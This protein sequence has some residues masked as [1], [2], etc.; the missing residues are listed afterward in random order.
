[1]TGLYRSMPETFA[2]DL[3]MTK[4]AYLRA[5]AVLIKAGLLELAPKER[6]LWVKPMMRYQGT[7]S[8][9]VLKYVRS[10]LDSLPPNPLVE[11]FCQAYP[12]VGELVTVRKAR[13]ARRMEEVRAA[14]AG[15]GSGTIILFPQRDETTAAREATDRMREP[16]GIPPNT[17]DS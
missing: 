6:F 10:Y 16:E 13:R 12:E 14:Q 3:G 5:Q 1:M 17:E 7:T 9:K 15:G 8:P 4:P 11:A 2:E